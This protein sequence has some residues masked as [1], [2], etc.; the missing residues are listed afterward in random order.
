MEESWPIVDTG[1]AALAAKLRHQV[2]LGEG[3][4]LFESVRKLSLYR[5]VFVAFGPRWTK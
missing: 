4:Q 1:Q 5:N 2:A 3:K